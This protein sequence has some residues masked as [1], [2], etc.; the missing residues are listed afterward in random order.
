MRWCRV[1]RVDGL[2]CW[3]LSVAVA[4]GNIEIVAEHRIVCSLKLA[5]KDAMTLGR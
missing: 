3:E 2:P 4:V 1:A 5:V